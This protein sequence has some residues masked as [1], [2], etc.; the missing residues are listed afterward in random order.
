ML[1]TTRPGRVLGYSDAGLEPEAHVSAGAVRWCDGATGETRLI[2]LGASCA[3]RL[4]EVGEIV[5]LV[6]DLEPCLDAVHD[7]EGSMYAVPR[8]RLRVV[9]LRMMRRR[10]EPGARAHQLER[11]FAA[12]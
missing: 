12:R 9:D 11:R 5:A 8:E 7:R 3:E 4:P 1:V 10:G 2:P 6:L